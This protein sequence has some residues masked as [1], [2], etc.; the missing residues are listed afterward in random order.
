[1]EVQHALLTRFLKLLYY[2]HTGLAGA[3]RG[4]FKR[5]DIAFRDQALATRVL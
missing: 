2:F 4:H 3:C 1:M 5:I